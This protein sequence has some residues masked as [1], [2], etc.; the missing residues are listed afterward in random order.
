MKLLLILADMKT[1]ILSKVK[2]YKYKGHTIRAAK[3]GRFKVYTKS[4]YELF[5]RPTLKEAKASISLI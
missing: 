5:K 4:G 2:T 3:S 1:A